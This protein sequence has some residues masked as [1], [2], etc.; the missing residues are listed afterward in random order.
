MYPLLTSDTDGEV[1]GGRALIVR[2]LHREVPLVRLADLGDVQYARRTQLEPRD[3]AG[4]GQ[5]DRLT[6]Q[7]ILL[8]RGVSV[9]AEVETP[10]LTSDDVH[11]LGRDGL[12]EFRF[13]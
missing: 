7:H 6:E 10:A 9:G 1:V 4:Q 8:G 13:D 11:H 12:V 2:G 3:V 5:L